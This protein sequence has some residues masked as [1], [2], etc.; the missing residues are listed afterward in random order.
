MIDASKWNERGV[1]VVQVSSEGMKG[2]D[3]SFETG[4]REAPSPPPSISKPFIHRGGELKEINNRT[5]SLSINQNKSIEKH[6][7]NLYIGS[8]TTNRT[9]VIRKG[10]KMKRFFFFEFVYRVNHGGFLFYII[11]SKIFSCRN[12]KNNE[13]LF[14]FIRNKR[15]EKIIMKK[16]VN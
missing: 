8:I 15:E 4:W 10:C 1:E 14:V 12:N 13:S 5:D 16:I 11:C 3:G 9:R 6:S 2:L 7:R